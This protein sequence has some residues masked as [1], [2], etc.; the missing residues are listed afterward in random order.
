MRG[1]CPALSPINRVAPAYRTPLGNSEL[2]RV[3][4]EAKSLKGVAR[5]AFQV[6]RTSPL[7]PGERGCMPAST[8]HQMS[9]AD[10]GPFLSLSW[11][12]LGSVQ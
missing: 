3:W 10:F 6:N 5:R 8:T 9:T 2:E 4:V 7:P 12:P 11:T 1:V